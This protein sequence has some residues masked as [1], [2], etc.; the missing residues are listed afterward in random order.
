MGK[1]TSHNPLQKEEEMYVVLSVIEK[2]D[3]REL[4]RK[5]G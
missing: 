4:E 3:A 1:E 2:G 5:V